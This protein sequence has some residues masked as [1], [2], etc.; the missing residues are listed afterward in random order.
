VEVL[1]L[2]RGAH[3]P[4]VYSSA[5]VPG[6][7]DE[8]RQRP[9]PTRDYGMCDRWYALTYGESRC[10]HFGHASR[11]QL[12]AWWS[13]EDLEFLLGQGIQISVYEV[14]EHAVIEGAF[15][16]AFIRSVATFKCTTEVLEGVE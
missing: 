12:L 3:G 15:Q 11:G 8:V 7:A 6:R 10:Y 9:P 1:R 16:V 13:L 14:P 5:E 4:G 2:E